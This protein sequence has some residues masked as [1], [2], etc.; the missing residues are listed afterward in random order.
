M[1][2]TRDPGAGPENEE[3]SGYESVFGSLGSGN[4]QFSKPG[5][6]ALD[7][8]GNV[9]VADTENNRVEEFSAGGTYILKFGTVGSGNGH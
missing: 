1:T 8:E 4:G 2:E 3:T 6:I 9:W 7:K 5:A